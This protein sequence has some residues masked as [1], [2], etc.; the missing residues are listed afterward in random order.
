[1]AIH[2]FYERGK[3]FACNNTVH[4]WVEN[5]RENKPHIY[6]RGGEWCVVKCGSHRYIEKDVCA[7]LNTKAIRWMLFRNGEL[8]GTNER[9]RVGLAKIGCIVKKERV[10]A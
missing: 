4:K 2:W 1:M 6:F 3:H 7:E 5:V 9:L 8:D 10:D